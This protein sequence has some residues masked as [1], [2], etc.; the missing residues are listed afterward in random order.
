ME[1]CCLR[2]YDSIPG[3]GVDK[4]AAVD[5]HIEPEAV[6]PLSEPLYS[7]ERDNV[8]EVSSLTHID[9]NVAKEDSSGIFIPLPVSRAQ[10]LKIF[11]VEVAED[12]ITKL[13]GKSIRT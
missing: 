4:I 13:M 6:N 7:S 1:W 12:L 3:K 8:F 2:S 5:S 10:L 11:K 9:T